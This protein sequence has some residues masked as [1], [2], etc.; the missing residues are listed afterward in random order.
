MATSNNN[1]EI[2]PII[3]SPS[4]FDSKTGGLVERTI[5]NNRLVVIVL[6]L[7][8]SGVLGTLS[9]RLE[10]EASFADMMPQSH[11]YVRNYFEHASSLGNMGNSIRIVVEN[12]E[13]DIYDAEY[14]ATLQEFNDEVFLLPG[15]DRSF[16]KSLWMPVVRWSQIT[17][18]GFEGGP[19][20]PRDYD[21]SDQSIEDL[22]DNV[23]RSGIEG[24]LVSDDHKS[25]MIFVPLSDSEKAPLDYKAFYEQLEA[26]RASYEEQ[27]VRIHI[28]GFA[29]LVGDLT[30]GLVEVLSYF[31]YAAMLACLI[32]LVYTRSFRCT[33]AIIGCSIIA[34]VWQL[35]VMQAMGFA[36]DPFSVLIPFLIFAIGVS[37]GAQ[38]TNGIMQDIGRG[39][40]KYV[41]ARFTFRRLFLAGL[42]AVLG[43]AVG[44]AVLSVIDIPAIRNL[45][46]A[47][48]IGVMMLI[49]TN[50]VLL[51]VLLSY[52][53]VGKAA[54]MR[55][56]KSLS[57]S[58]PVVEWF[59]GFTERRRAAF[60]IAFSAVL[61]AG[62]WVVA[63]DLKIG[64]L[65]P[66]APELRSDSTYNK[67]NAYITDRYQLS[68]DQFA[69]IVST[70]SQG[71]ID[72]ETLLEMDR[73]EQTL[74]ELPG[75]Q[76]TTSV[77]SVSRQF[78]TVGFEGSP[79]WA[80]IA[81]DSFVIQDAI[82][83][84]S[85]TN[86]ELFNTDRSVAPVIAFLTDHKADTL[87]RLV[88]TVEEFAAKHNTEDRKFLLAAG[89]SGIE[90]ATNIVVKKANRTMLFYVYG[91]VIVLCLIT[92][93]SWRAVLVAILPLMLTTILCEALMVLL[94][95]GVKVATLPVT[96]LGVG[97]GVDYALYLIA[98]HLLYQRQGYSVRDSYIEALC[99]T[100]KVV[101]LIGCMLS[102]AVITWAWSPIKFQADMGILLAFMFLMN[103]LGAL[104][105]VPSLA[106]F[107]MPQKKSN[108][109]AGEI[110][111]TQGMGTSL[112][113]NRDLQYSSTESRNLQQTD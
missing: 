57:A 82:N 112:N 90:A 62:G 63:K 87:A 93:R 77:A 36:L 16:M 25:S 34:V 98:M 46:A 85:D 23:H 109:D 41:A 47:A 29:Q 110:T 42:T 39:T 1:G 60:A 5:F 21:G 33:A 100:G 95:I 103:M 18:D 111:D 32:L 97:I 56:R 83:I 104:I 101:A 92:F 80:T 43:D 108:S 89:N 17:V 67:D 35:G 84:V 105:L 8:L 55:S 24:S 49:F 102:L 19:V 70:P 113:D 72:Y 64:D 2:M 73:L 81:R 107:L 6:C 59:A 4:E 66:G 69:V 65:D 45:A 94:G 9:M 91:V 71:L 48:S 68:S 50:L 38:K 10:I 74:R 51:P 11:E 76:T 30:K 53:G 13:G 106:I 52:F 58:H 61:A 31:L 28:I 20:M 44:F 27:G 88:E 7:L 15:V 22:R 96:A 86:P 37:H 75:V 40:H 79:K 12:A 54:E 78:T 14:L 3:S 99:S 26:L